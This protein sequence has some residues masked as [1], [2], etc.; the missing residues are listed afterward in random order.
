MRFAAYLHRSGRPAAGVVDGDG[1]SVRPF[2]SRI[3][4]EDYLDLEPRE[5]SAQARDL[6]EPVA[7]DEVSL[8]APVRPRKNVFCVGRNYAAHAEEGARARGVELKLPEVPTFFTKAP[9]AIADPDAAL[10]LDPN[11]SPQ[12][13][14]EAELAVIIGER[15][16]D[17]PETAALDVVFGY[18]CLNDVTARDL[19]RAHGQWFK[20]KSL[21]NTCPIGPWIVE[22]GDIRDPQTLDLRL[23]VNGDEK[24]HSNTS[25]MIFPVAKIIAVLSRGLTL[26][27]GDVIATGTPEGVGFARTPP[28]FL[29][30]GDVMEVA[31]EKIGTLRNPVRLAA[32]VAATM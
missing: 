30:D 17:V 15:C 11:L 1:R 7:L 22:R 25:N 21:D 20:G 28:E 32:A 6:G 2:R 3:S 12:Y 24:Q 4:L 27:P 26:E 14:W 23:T 31:I 16:R 13:D 9:T 29:K 19:Q 5:R 10:E 8:L 18:T